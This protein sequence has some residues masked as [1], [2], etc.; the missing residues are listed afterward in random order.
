MINHLK[1]TQL[2]FKSY[3]TRTFSGEPIR[4]GRI[5][6]DILSSLIHMNQILYMQYSL[7]L[8]FIINSIYAQ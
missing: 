3:I 7:M 4:N 5:L 1:K 8:V 6:P 2:L